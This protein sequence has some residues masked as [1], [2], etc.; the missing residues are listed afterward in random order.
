MRITNNSGISL[1]L[2]VWLLHDTYD[3]I[4][5]PNYIS[6]TTLMKPLRQII[7]PKRI[8]PEQVQTDVED[9]IARS[10]GHAIH[11]S[12]E[13]AW[14][15]GYERSMRLMGYPDDVIAKIRINPSDEEIVARRATGQDTIPVYL[16]QR[17]FR[18]VTVNGVTYVIGGKYDMVAD[19]LV[20]DTKSTSVWGWVKGT[21]DEDHALQMSFYR[22]LDAGRENPRITE[23]Y[24]K[25]NYVFTDW[26]KAMS[27]TTPNY[28]AKRVETKDITLYT[29]EQMDTWIHNKL[30]LVQQ[31]QDTPEAEL[32]EC[33]DEELWR[34]A[35]VHKYF[36]DPTKVNVPG[37]RATKNFDDLM[38]ARKFQAEKGGKGTI[39]TIPGEVKACG[40]CPAFD[41]C[42]Q[43]DRYL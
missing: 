19:G 35:P 28:P 14:K 11:D 40:Y 8:P 37:A 12:M 6:V 7:I 31:Y 43:K 27:K 5:K 3:Y 21:K 10:L 38:E 20:N 34:S 13:Q 41:G 2:A 17:E 39:V 9:Y 4:D 25:I 36:S 16:E 42:T 33:T 1:P 30:S 32:P 23:D 26:S 15:D 22:W 18:E 29:L 24:G